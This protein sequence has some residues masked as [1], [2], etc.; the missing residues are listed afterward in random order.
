MSGTAIL[1]VVTAVTKDW[2]KQRKAE[3]REAS[4]KLRRHDALTQTRRM[5]I[6]EAAYE[7][8][9]QAYLKASANG[10]LPAHARQIMYAARGQIQKMTGKKLDD[11]YF[12][13]TLLP[14]FM[15]DYP[16]R[17]RTW[18]VVFDARGHITEP[19]TGKVVPLGTIAVRQYLAAAKTGPDLEESVP[20]L[21]TS[22]P[23]C[24]PS[25][26]YGAIL[27]VEKEGF[28][29][30]FEKV[31]LAE[32]YDIAI[33]STKGM[34]VTAARLLVDRLCHPYGDGVPLLVMR[35]FDKA[36]FSIAGTLQRDTRRYEFRSAPRVTDL[37]LRLADVREWDLESEEVI[38]GK[39]KPTWNLKEN[40]ATGEE[41]AFLYEGFDPWR[42]HHGRRVELNA[43]PSDRLIKW[44]EGKLDEHGVAKVIPDVE[45]LTAAYRRAVARAEIQHAI[46]KVQQE[47]WDR[48]RSLEPPADLA[49]R[50]LERVKDTDLAWDDA[51]GEMVNKEHT[52]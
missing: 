28:M 31:N 15:L 13:Q 34:S 42:G 36:G 14:D 2:T 41:I 7:V 19:H 29:P 26:R 35:D 27:F 33:M 23:T 5:N 18:D 48:A 49:E 10:T 22:Y 30:L 24:G 40:D 43:F 37:G 45:T 47:A 9:E 17:T 25:H 32:R 38:Y 44:I 51:L 39:T 6:K 12:T 46:D 50:L 20:Q 8:M 3:E 1:D 52:P 4:R 16:D 11:A 21:E